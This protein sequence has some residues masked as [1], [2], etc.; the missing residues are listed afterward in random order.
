[1]KRAIFFLAVATALTLALGACAK[2][3]PAPK[4]SAVELPA[5]PATLEQLWSV[6]IGG[7]FDRDSAAHLGIAAV[8]E[9]LFAVSPDGEVAAVNGA[10][11]EFLWRRELEV[12]LI[13]GAGAGE[14]LVFAADVDGVVHALDAGDGATLWS[15]PVRGEV[16]TAPR[17]ELGVV[18]VRTADGRVAG[19]SAD[20]GAEQWVFRKEEPGLSVRGSA[21]PLLRGNLVINAFAGG[22]VT[23]N[24]LNSGRLLWEFRALDPVGSNEIELLADIDAQPL[25]ADGAL[26]VA[27]YQSTVIAVDAEDPSGVLWHAEVS[28]Y[29]DMA[30]DEARLFT[31]DLDGVVHA[32][33]R[34]DGTAV[35]RTEALRGL[36]VSVPVV[37][38]EFVVVGT[39]KGTLFL[40]DRGDGTVRGRFKL[41]AAVAAAVADGDGA[42]IFLLGVDGR[43]SALSAR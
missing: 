20:S 35:W 29:L 6:K 19:L 30:A 7:G 3:K 9:V 8:G 4:E 34:D 42:R 40:L 38:G 21:A 18:V 10:D 43:L 28:T 11:G 1:M 37:A 13:S 23:A 36:A 17:A 12:D 16:L 33:S 32:L 24:E 41:G 27:A 2:K 25:A 14:G 22:E 31:V 5:A 39:R 15:A 26:F